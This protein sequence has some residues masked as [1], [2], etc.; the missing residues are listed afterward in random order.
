MFCPQTWT[1]LLSLCRP[2]RNFFKV[3]V[4][5]S[6][7][8]CQIP[9]AVLTLIRAVGSPFQGHLHLP[10]TQPLHTNNW[11]RVPLIV[12]YGN[13][14]CGA[15]G[16]IALLPYSFSSSED[17]N[18]GGHF[19]AVHICLRENG[20]GKQRRDQ[21]ALRVVLG[22]TG[23][24]SRRQNCLLGSQ[25][26]LSGDNFAVIGSWEL[27]EATSYLTI[28]NTGM[29]II[30]GYENERNSSFVLLLSQESHKQTKRHL[31]LQAVYLALCS[32]TELE[33][34]LFKKNFKLVNY[35]VIFEKPECLCCAG[36]TPAGFS[37]VLRL[38]LFASNILTS[39][40]N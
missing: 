36:K 6:Y 8:I 4:W 16:G 14:S 20:A 38:P 24:G 9:V 31:S 40:S 26:I 30:W 33:D 11:A 37:I 7:P 17:R 5:Y 15:P 35:S 10:L 27:R 18:W 22:D 3:P 39:L 28:L 1:P 25:T 29:W 23:W 2:M 13:Q 21:E 34:T 12:S 32:W 19:L